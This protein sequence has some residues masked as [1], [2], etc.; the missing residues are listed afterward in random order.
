MKTVTRTSMNEATVSEFP[1]WQRI[2][3]ST[4]WTLFLNPALMPMLRTQSNFLAAVDQSMAAWV[5][6]RLEGLAEAERIVARLQDS[7]TPGEVVSLQREW[8]EH[9]LQRFFADAAQCQNSLM[10]LAGTGSDSPEANAA[11]SSGEPEPAAA[12]A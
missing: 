3:S 9:A 12:E 6:N 4:C 8:M 5:R 2:A 11:P 10:L 1:E 7:P